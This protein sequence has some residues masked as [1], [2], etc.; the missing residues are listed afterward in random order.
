MTKYK[1][2]KEYVEEN[3]LD[4][5]MKRLEPYIISHK[6]DL[7][8][9][10]FYNISWVEVIGS[11]VCGIT[12]KDIGDNWIEIRTSIDVEIEF[13][14]KTRYGHDSDTATKT[15]NVFLKAILEDGLKKVS[16]TDV[17]SY[18]KNIYEKDKSLSQNLVPYMYEED[19]ERHAEDFL[20]KHYQKALLQPM[21][22]PVEE[23]VDDM[24]M[25]FFYAPLEDGIFG[26]T[27]FGEEKVKV[28]TDIT[29]SEEIEIM[30]SPGTML[31]NPNVYFMYNIG[32]ANNT[33]I[34][35][36]VHWDRHRRPFE[37]Q[38]LLEGDCS[39]ISCE[40]VEKY[41]GIP[42][43]ASAF[44]WM[45]WQANQLAPRIL[46]PAKMTKRKLNDFLQAR[47]QI[48]PHERFAIHME[49]A[50]NDLSL[51]FHVSNIAAKLRAI[52]LG[53]DQ[54]Q[55]VQV[56]CN[57]R[58]L[59]PFAFMKGTLN[60][61]NTFVIDENNLLYNLMVRPE[62]GRLYAEG[63]IVYT[64]CMLCLNT[65]KYIELSETGEPILTDYALEHV[66]ECCYIFNRRFS[67]SDS[68][69][70]T[71]YRRCFLC[72]DVDS[73]TFIEAD[74]DE[75]HKSNQSK[76]DKEKELSIITDFADGMAEFME[77]LPGAFSKT[78]RAHMVR[79]KIGEEELAFRCHLS[80]QTISKYLNH[81]GEKKKYENVLA[82][83]K[84]LCLHPIYMEDLIKK[85][86]FSTDK[87]DRAS[88]IVKFLI[89]HHPD[90]T[91]EEWQEKL[92]DAHVSIKL[93]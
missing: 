52:E 32:T 82:V 29:G 35:E 79:K 60:K 6:D 4:M 22:L 31:I 17:S 46:M 68:Y 81:N 90:D 75:E 16:V 69:S 85:A 26:K 14:G 57:G 61:N 45:E 74:Y 33:I 70:D 1:D 59:P 89:W 71:F 30:T 5:I 83:G 44:K 92:D 25:T 2:F 80:V 3:Y 42:E 41:E 36:C 23:I 91:I 8:E 87:S 54:A 28:Y 73:E 58:R 43:E 20:K 66:D 63:K 18:D 15:Y 7:E 88:I 72:R 56:Y 67:A 93:P 11:S 27:F 77:D 50:I 51:F 55:G 9:D 13:T 21:P 37:L 40:I 65:P 24:G 19:V 34:H 64:N 12:F 38:R 62:L 78:L 76:A 10:D 39:H 49:G 84:A 53:Y 48:N 86:G 47:Y